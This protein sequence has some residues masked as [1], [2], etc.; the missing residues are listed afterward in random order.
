MQNSDPGDDNNGFGMTTRLPRNHAQSR[1]QLTLSWVSIG[2]SCLLLAAFAVLAL[3][4]A[5]VG[6]YSVLAYAVRRRVREIGIRIALGAS[7]PGVVR[8][9]IVDAL[10]PTLAGVGLGLA[11]A[12]AI[13]QVMAS[14]AVGPSGRWSQGFGTN[15]CRAGGR[16]D[17]AGAEP[18]DPALDRRVRLGFQVLPHQAR[19]YAG[20]LQRPSPIARGDE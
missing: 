10:R 1:S 3:V 17:V 8:M 14:L 2:G 13:R 9:V 7:A 19:V 5:A 18:G 12:I 16:G 20:E 15:R 11:G 4:L 6:I